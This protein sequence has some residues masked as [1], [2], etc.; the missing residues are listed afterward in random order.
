MSHAIILTSAIAIGLLLIAKMAARSRAEDG[1]LSLSSALG[2]SRSAQERREFFC[3]IWKGASPEES[4]D[5]IVHRA[6]A[7][8]G[9]LA[10]ADELVQLVSCHPRF[11]S[12]VGF[13]ARFKSGLENEKTLTSSPAYDLPLCLLFREDAKVSE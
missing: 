6:M 5:S 12:D 10:R 9:G 4:A 8:C 7:F 13:G 1:S 2:L 3:G 11:I